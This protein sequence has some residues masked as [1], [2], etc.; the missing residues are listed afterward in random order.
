MEQT[1]FEKSFISFVE[2]LFHRHLIYRTHIQMNKQVI[3]TALA[4]LFVTCIKAQSFGEIRGKVLGEE[5][6]LI[7]GA[8]V[9]VDNGIEQVATMTGDDGV[10]WVKPL[11]PGKYDV[12][13]TAV[14]RDTVLITGVRVDA[15]KINMMKD[16]VLKFY[17]YQTGGIEITEYTRPL[18][19]KGGD[20]L[21]TWDADD[22]KNL[23]TAN[24]GKISDIVKTMSSDI[25]VGPQGGLSIRGSREG[26]VLYF[27]DGVKM[28][29]TDVV[30]PS[31]GIG[32]VSVYTGGIPA[33][34]GDTTAGVVIV[35]T[36]SYLEEYYK[37]LNQ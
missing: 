7:Y 3:C 5:K 15:D 4:V 9:V 35:E 37:K 20:H 1:F 14:G 8:L 31:S 33:K 29:D 16:A 12:K 6:E 28:R 26:G 32:S 13:I 21:Q 19:Y 25:K 17:A 22:L 11:R 23:P 30:V 10:Y 24:G 18:L 34:Y 2:F 27:V 36:K